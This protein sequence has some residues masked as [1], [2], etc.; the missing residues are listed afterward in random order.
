MTINPD[1]LALAGNINEYMT[2]GEMQEAGQIYRALKEIE[3]EESITI[4]L[5][6][7]LGIA[8]GKRQERA[9]RKHN[10]V[11]KSKEILLNCVREFDLLSAESEATA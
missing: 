8:V 4:M 7:Q 6:Y 1:T 9:R 3:R 2:Y 10:A 11:S 5:L